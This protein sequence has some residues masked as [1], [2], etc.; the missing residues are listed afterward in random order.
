[1][2]ARVECEASN[3]YPCWG[4]RTSLSDQGLA[5]GSVNSSST[6]ASSLGLGVLDPF[7]FGE[8]SIDLSVF[9][10]SA[11][12]CT[13]FSSVYLKSRSSDSFSAAMK[14]FILPASS[15]ISNCG[16]IKLLKTD[17]VDTPLPGATFV[18]YNDDG[19]G[20]PGVWADDDSVATDPA[21]GSPLTCTT[22]I[23]SDGAASCVVEN[24]LF[25]S[26]WAVET[27]VPVNHEM[28]DPV[29]VTVTED[30]DLPVVVGPIVDQ[31]SRGALKIVKERK[32]A[33]SGIGL[34]HPHAGVTF[35][36]TGGPESV[37]VVDS[38]DV[39]GVICIDG[40]LLGEYTV[41]ETVPAGYAAAGDVSKVVEVTNNDG[42]CSDGSGTFDVVE[43]LNIPLTVVSVSVDSVVDGGTYSSISC[44]DSD[45][46]SVLSVDAIGGGAGP[47]DIS[48]ST[49]ELLPGTYTCTIVVDP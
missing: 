11:E 8:A 39:G 10:T 17:D 37:L 4:G 29:W 19:A 28:A 12:E 30:D 45:G 41:T 9:F 49:G 14:D 35:T 44:V 2:R 25:G 3:K 22:A 31:R 5:T 42:D 32:H 47:D 6:D 40:L 38:T 15:E 27:V 34:N 23:D 26:Y 16:S 48:G 1:M 13:T 18:L 36:L 46:V 43:F 24:V 20:S 33:A 7:T 21:D